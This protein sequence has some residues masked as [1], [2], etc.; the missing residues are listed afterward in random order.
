MHSFFGIGKTIM[1]G[2]KDASQQYD[3]AIAAKNAGDQ[4]IAIKHIEEAKRRLSGVKEWYDIG[5]R[6]I[7]TEKQGSIAED[8]MALLNQQYREL[9]DKVNQFKL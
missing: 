8:I 3:F 7:A 2:C 1:D 6:Y 5:M 4:E 9:V